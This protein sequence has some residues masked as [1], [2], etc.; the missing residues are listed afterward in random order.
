M[1][2]VLHSDLIEHEK[3]Y[4]SDLEAKLDRLKKMRNSNRSENHN[5]LPKYS[6]KLIDK[7]KKLDLL[8]L[9]EE[10]RK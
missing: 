9:L 7:I 3:K 5:R 6:S 4:L 10:R 8:N 2:P 1:R